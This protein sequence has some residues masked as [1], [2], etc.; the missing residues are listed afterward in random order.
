MLSPVTGAEHVL[1]VPN[2]PKDKKIIFSV[3]S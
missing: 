2:V 3:T 1:H